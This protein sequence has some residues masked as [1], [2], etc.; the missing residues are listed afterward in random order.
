M[1]FH[2]HSLSAGQAQ[3]HAAPHAHMLRSEKQ[4]EHEEP[5]RFDLLTDAWAGAGAMASAQLPLDQSSP[6]WDA[7]A[8]HELWG[9]PPVW[10]LVREDAPQ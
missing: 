6:S 3:V 8:K 2:V 5:L 10:A 4:A 9:S 1:V 7:S